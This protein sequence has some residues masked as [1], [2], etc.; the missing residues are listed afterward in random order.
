MT[1][2]GQRIAA[3]AAWMLFARFAERGL[4]F[5]S[6]LILARLLMPEDFGLIAMAMSVSALLTLFSDFS[7]DLA[8]I[9]NQEATRE[10]YDTAWTL[11]LLILVLNGIALLLLAFPAAWLFDDPR[12]VPVMAMLALASVVGGF[13][14]VGVVAFLKELD[15]RKEFLYLGG[16]KLASFLT[17]I[18][19]AFVLG[20]YWA[21]IV[22]IV[23][24]V[25]MGVALS[26]A[27][28][29]YRPRFSLKHWRELVG[30][31]K[32]VLITNLADFVP[33]HFATFVLGPIT[34]ATTLGVYTVGA[35]LA[36]LPTTELVAPIDRAV[37]P[38]YAKLAGNQAALRRQYLSV[39]GL[40]AAFGLPAALGVAAIAPLAV[41]VLLG[42]KWLLA[43]VVVQTLAFAGAAHVLL[44]NSSAVFLAI[45]KPWLDAAATAIHALVLVVLIPLFA[46][47]KGLHGALVATLIAWAIFLPLSMW[48][49]MRELKIRLTELVGVLWRPLVAALGMAFLVDLYARGTE[50]PVTLIAL[51][52]AVGLGVLCYGGLAATAWW[53]AGRPDG[54]ETAVLSGVNRWMEARRA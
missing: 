3:G 54:A 6:T 20:N 35:E 1:S 28:H 33:L 47:W 15:F 16:K 9:R 14:N 21:L 27:L 53:L 32:W 46:V 7:F 34:G 31:S 42:E 18:P 10:H 49:V 29:P 12:V 40:I 8:L 2:I 44:S 52:S 39:L 11:G 5:L 50:M 36:R 23:A 45:N 17:T 43:I 38:A 37:Y 48:L 4:G 25:A 24:G 19:L 22:G 30:F 41:P 26:Y 51:L 13:E